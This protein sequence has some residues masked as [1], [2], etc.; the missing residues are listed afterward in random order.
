MKV[1]VAVVVYSAIVTT[2]VG[3]VVAS[4]VVPL[5]ESTFVIEA[6]STENRLATIWILCTAPFPGQ[7]PYLTFIEN[8]GVVC[9]G[10][11]ITPNYIVSVARGCLNRSTIKTAQHGT[12][13]LAFNNNMWEQ[14][15]NLSAS[16]INLYPY[17]DI[18]LARLDYPATLN[19]HV[20]PIR[21][22]KLSGS[23]S[24][25]DMEGTTVAT[26]YVRNRV[27][28]NSEC[29]KEHTYFNA[30]NVD[31]CTDRYIGGAFCSFFLGSPLTIEDENGVILI[32]LAIW[33]SSCDNYPTGYA[34]IS[35]LRDWIHNNSDYKNQHCTC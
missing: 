15:I 12:A 4:D 19:K 30:T 11:L 24:Y 3:R 2:F 6:L 14:R 13:I 23:R 22:P 10:A 27:M 20:Q 17:E 26:N 8:N 9:N 34:R 33:I 7:F 32:G 31:I 25:V 1:S 21:L 28:S 35:P 18:A 16:A 29:T 5:Q